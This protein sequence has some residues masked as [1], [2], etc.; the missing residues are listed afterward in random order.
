MTGRTHEA[1]GV[2][3]A[4]GVCALAT[5]SPTQGAV[6]VGCSF[7]TSR[8]PDRLEMGV[9]PHRGPTHW[10]LT[11]GLVIACLTFAASLTVDTRPFAGTVM[12]GVACG[13][14]MHLAADM[15]T[16]T[17]VPLYGPFSG[18]DRHL[19]PRGHRF[20]TGQLGDRFIALLAVAASIGLGIIMFP[21]S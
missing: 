13:Y 17:G 14:L 15:C 18:R 9:L 21:A 12:A 19:L 10:L 6:L 1:I 8:L 11:A 7:V 20:V 4:L 2:A 5:P 16:I 3:T